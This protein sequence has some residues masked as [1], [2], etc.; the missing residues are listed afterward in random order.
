MKGVTT[1]LESKFPS[2][3][4]LLWDYNCGRCYL[5]P[6]TSPFCTMAMTRNYYNNVHVDAMDP[7]ISFITWWLVGDGTLIGGSFLLS[8]AFLQFTPLQGTLLCINT[9]LLYH[10][11]MPC[12]QEGHIE[13]I[14][15]AIWHR[16]KV[17]S[18]FL[19]KT[20]KARGPHVPN[21]SSN[22]KACMEPGE[23]FNLDAVGS[24]DA[25]DCWGWC[26]VPETL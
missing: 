11:T 13:R 5:G 4:K 21:A 18:A 17:I 20:N 2:Q 22:G 26:P 10:G 23:L 12:I 6:G 16:E 19:R 24:L 3:L 7:F 1:E 25:T 9:R 15:S 8:N 14:G